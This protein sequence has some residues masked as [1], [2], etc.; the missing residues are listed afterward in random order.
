[1]P[2]V[3]CHGRRVRSSLVI[4]ATAALLSLS[5]SGL[6]TLEVFLGPHD[7]VTQFAQPANHRS[8][9]VLV[10]EKAHVRVASS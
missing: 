3:F 2:R 6:Y 5:S 8:R 4:V 1:M 9:D 10:R 7:V